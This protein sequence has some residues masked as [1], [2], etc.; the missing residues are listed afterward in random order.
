MMDIDRIRTV[1]SEMSLEEKISLCGCGANLVSQSIPRLRVKSVALP[2]GIFSSSSLTALGCSF[3]PALCAEY[4]AVCGVTAALEGSALAGPLNIGV[5]RTPYDEGSERMFSEDPLVVAKLAD[6]V[7]EGS[8]IKILGR[9]AL[10]GEYK[11]ARRRMDTRALRERYLFP[12]KKVGHKLGGL[13]ID[14]G[15]FDGQIISQSPQC[16]SLLSEY[17][18]S[19]ALMVNE[20]GSTISMPLT[21]ASGA[22]Y[23]PAFTHAD[24]SSLYNAVKDG[25]IHEKRLD[26][27]LQRLLQLVCEYNESKSVLTAP[28]L[29]DAF[30][31][32]L[33]LSSS[34]LLKNDGVLPISKGEQI[35][36]YGDLSKAKIAQ[37]AEFYQ[38]S[39]KKNSGKIAVAVI[40]LCGTEYTLE[41]TSLIEK[42]SRSYDTIVV[43]LA[44][45]PA[46][47][48][49]EQF[50]KAI[51]YVPHDNDN[52]GECLATLLCGDVNPRGKMNVTYAKKQTDYPAYSYKKASG[53][54]MFC[55]ESLIAGHTYFSQFNVEPLYPFGHGLSYTDFEISKLTAQVQDETINVS[56]VVKNVGSVSGGSTV[57]TFGSLPYDGIM[58]LRNRL[59]AFNSVY[60][61]EHENVMVNLTI[62]LNDFATYNKHGNEWII[63]GGKLEL[64][65]GF[66]ATDIR[67]NITVKIPRATRYVVGVDKKGAPS[68]FASNGF[69]PLGSEVE[70]VME[71][72]LIARDEDN[73]DYVQ[74]TDTAIRKKSEKILVKKIAKITNDVYSAKKF[75]AELSDYA[76]AKLN[77]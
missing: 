60:L 32:R 35:G 33:C 55:H 59:Y 7:I 72:T 18:D 54:G 51:F 77:K 47:L 66:S 62:D 74:K 2:S 44:D 43:L 40:K 76:V 28:E 67:A 6:A 37:M 8:P 29:S 15:T 64:M 65:V 52:L 46:P 14:G 58:G 61:D 56:Y 11:F 23:V 31:A 5:I 50:A 75:V 48:P 22:C 10:G 20:P 70:R 42:L 68:Y 24:M 12:L 45:R 25:V 73:A 41:Q 1:I 27:N 36:V 69:N 17:L 30:D 4:G 3:S 16:V 21:L 39:T 9:G 19:L 13:I 38:V 34:V 49:F 53:R 26:V 57:F 63:P 71:T